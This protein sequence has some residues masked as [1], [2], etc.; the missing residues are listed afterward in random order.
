MPAATTPGMILGTVGYMSPEQGRGLATDGRADIFALGVILYE[1]LSGRR[2]FHGA[3]TAETL[4]ALMRDEP[5]ALSR[6]GVTVPAALDRIIRRCLEK[7]PAA[8]FQSAHDLAFALDTATESGP[9]SAATGPASTAPSKSLVVLPF[10]NMSHEAENE[11]LADGLTEEIIADLSKL[12]D[13]RVISRTSALQLKGRRD[14]ANI[15]PE[16]NV[17]YVLSGSVRRAGARLRITAQLIDG[18]NDAQLWSDKYSGTMDDVFDMQEQVSRAIA[19]EL[20]IKLSREESREMAERPITDP[21]AYEC[22]LRA[23]G[24]VIR[25]TED[26]LDRALRD[27]RHAT[28]MIGP[29]VPLLAVEGD[30]HLQYYNMGLDTA[31]ARLDEVDRLVRR[32]EAIEP[33]SPHALRLRALHAVHAAGDLAQAMQLLAESLRS[34]P[35]DVFTATLFVFGCGLLGVPERAEST[36]ALV[37]EIDPLQP[38]TH[39]A[40]GF[41]HSMQG[42]FE[43]SLPHLK[44]SLEL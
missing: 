35:N 12:R 4:A 21:R 32:I 39:A 23:R 3:T 9:A 19:R 41:L 26:G 36:A 42:R 16:L 6:L 20:E 22:Y 8:R 28:A 44:R 17:G 33:G 5:P 31:A 13:V 27:I 11:F 29:S 24:E 40:A 25:F 10:E 7:D 37:L 14:V 18:V 15:A 1:M 43:Q 38:L 2:A 30:I 34:D